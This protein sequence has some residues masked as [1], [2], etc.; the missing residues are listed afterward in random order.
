M[1][2]Y[3]ELAK[4]ADIPGDRWDDNYP[5]SQAIKIGRSIICDGYLSEKEEREGKKK[6]EVGLTAVFS[7]FHEDHTYNIKRT[8][9]GC[10]NIILSKTTYDAL[11]GM[12]K[13]TERGTFHVLE[14]PGDQFDTNYGE[15]IQLFDANH[16]PGSKQVLVTMD[17]G[18]RILYSGDFSY[19]NIPV[20]E[21]D[22][23]VLESE[24]GEEV[25]DFDT[26]KPSV[27]RSIW[28][29]V[30][31]EIE[32]GNPVEI[33]V[34]RG[35]MQDVMA[36]LEKERFNDE[37]RN[38][39]NDVSDNSILKKH[40]P[41]KIPF[42]ADEIDVNLTNAIK[43]KYDEDI[44]EIEIA[45]NDRLDE[46]HE[47]KEP[48]VRFATVG[49]ITPQ[50]DRAT[51]IQVDVNQGFKNHGA[52]FTSGGR[53]FACLA[54]HSSYTNVLEYVKATKA[55]IVMVDGTRASVQT[56]KELANGISEKLHKVAFPKF[57]KYEH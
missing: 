11:L 30:Y 13:I 41:R 31:K 17:S 19:P 39:V 16:V 15:K 8:F 2:E 56:A 34:H 40:I 18:E 23:L 35:T 44:R 51:V 24:H 28:R 43:H 21:A 32:S 53:Y 25:Y 46:L 14:K 27:L 48:Y 26:D 47:K 42:L 12:G 33:R 38:L 10:D 3:D 50:Q 57:C 49:R 6:E 1:N 45:K 29:H 37:D 4:L 55:K 22:L 9:T 52:F 54:A 36:E 7:H 5:N 20:P